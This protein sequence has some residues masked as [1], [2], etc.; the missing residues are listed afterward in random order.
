MILI[1]IG[2]G[3]TINLEG[4][5]SDLAEIKAPCIIV[6]GANALRN[7]LAQQLGVSKRILE[8]ASG[9]SS[10]FTDAPMIDLLMM[11][12]AG[13]RNKRIVELCQRHGINAVGLSGLDGR[14][15][16]GK[17]NPGIRVRDGDKT[18]MVHDLSGKPCT[19]NRELFEYLLAHQYTPVLSI[20]IID[21][22]N[23]A[24]NSENDDIVT[25]IQRE[26][27][28]PRILQFIEA[29]GF[30]KDPADSSSLITRLSCSELEQWEAI[31]HGRIKRKLLAVRKLFSQGP[32]HVTIADGRIEHPVREALNGRGTDIQ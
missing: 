13:V 8:S 21:E 16:Q 9:H 32:V 11:A 3:G 15:L 4:I 26:M 17:R 25:L 22:T 1:K 24:I 18:K 14:I 27:H 29:P 30:L 31:S 6:H 20:P 7:E 19:I 28:I 23:T 10:V 5:I 2:G 12:Y